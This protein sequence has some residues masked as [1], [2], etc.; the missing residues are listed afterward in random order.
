[1]VRACEKAVTAERNRGGEMERRINVID[2][3]KIGMYFLIALV[4]AE[5]STS[6]VECR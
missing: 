4:R 6:N 5:L 2:G 3:V 1:M